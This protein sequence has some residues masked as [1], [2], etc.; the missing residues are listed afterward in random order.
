MPSVASAAAADRGAGRAAGDGLLVEDLGEV[1]AERG[2][3]GWLGDRGRCRR[4][5]RVGDRLARL[6]VEGARV[7]LRDRGEVA[8]EPSR[9]GSRAG[10][11]RPWSAGPGRRL[12]S[13]PRRSRLQ[14]PASV[15]HA[16]RSVQPQPVQAR[17]AYA[18][19]KTSKTGPRVL[20]CAP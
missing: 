15:T 6:L 7:A 20:G 12:S 16:A 4:A 18:G 9:S 13:G 17:G 8:P 19:G 3:A 10:R 5:A 2:A 14:G 11:G 1:L